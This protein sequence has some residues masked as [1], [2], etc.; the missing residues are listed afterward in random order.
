MSKHIYTLTLR[1]DYC[2][3]SSIVKWLTRFDD[4]TPPASRSSLWSFVSLI[5]ILHFKLYIFITMTC[6]ISVCLFISLSERFDHHCPWVGNCVGRRN[7]RFFYSFIISL[8]FLTSFVFGCVITHIALRKYSHTAKQQ[9]GS[10]CFGLMRFRFFFFFFFL[11]PGSQ[12]GTSLVQA[13]QESP[14]R[15]PLVHTQ[16]LHDL[17]T[18]YAPLPWSKT[19]LHCQQSHFPA[20][21]PPKLTLNRIRVS[22]Q[23]HI[24]FRQ[25]AV[26]QVGFLLVYSHYEIPI[27]A[28][29]KST[30][31]QMKACVRQT[32]P[33]ENS[34]S[35][36]K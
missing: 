20:A 15:Y 29:L 16:Y 22:I 21:G 31:T 34:R 24:A 10:R 33:K 30:F 23:Q 12:A 9:T 2:R 32:E 8:S 5:S 28:C 1:S 27:S 36:A 26:E 18:C 35:R 17:L 25:I 13:I 11:F 14:A 3:I 19:Q 4:L 6:L 7:Y